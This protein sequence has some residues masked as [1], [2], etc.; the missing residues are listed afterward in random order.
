[1]K[2]HYKVLGIMSGTSLDGL[3]LCLVEFNQKGKQ[4]KYEIV[5]CETISYTKKWTAHLT[6]ATKFS[7]AKLCQLDHEYGKL[8]GREVKAF[9]KKN[10]QEVDLIASHGHTVY[11]QPKKGFTLQIGNG[12]AIAAETNCVIVSDF[13]SQDVALGGQGA[14]LVPLGDRDLFMQHEACLNIGGITNVSFQSNGKRIALDIAPSNL[15]L[16]KLSETFFSLTYDKDGEL[17]RKGVLRQNLIEQLDS[18]PY[19]RQP[20]PKSL[21]QEDIFPAFFN[22]LNSDQYSPIDLMHTFCKHWGKQVSKLLLKEGVSDN[23]LITGGGAKNKF[24]LECLDPKINYHLPEENLIDFKE[25][26][27]FAYL[28][29]KRSLNEINVLSSVTGATQDHSAGAIYMG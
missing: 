29:L 1:M 17:S 8:I 13:R 6:N 3:D 24:L 27:I 7:S 20:H 5:A 4:W 2:Q 21:G 15:I 22:L 12:A 9:L 18:W 14:P 26:L 19:Y 16:N 23:V 11:H 28:G 10:H 25:A